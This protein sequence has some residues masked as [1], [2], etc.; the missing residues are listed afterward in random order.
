LT[1]S[2]SKPKIQVLSDEIVKLEEKMK[3]NSSSIASAKEKITPIH[4]FIQNFK[5]KWAIISQVHIIND[6]EIEKVASRIAKTEQVLNKVKRLFAKTEE[7]FIKITESEKKE[8]EYGLYKQEIK[9]AKQDLKKWD[10]QAKSRSI[11]EKEIDLVKKEIMRFIS[12]EIRPLT[13]I[14]NTLYLRAQGNRFINSIEARPSKEGFLEWIADLNEA[15]VSFD[16]MSSLSQGQRQDLALAI[17]L[18]RARSLGGTF[19]L[20]EPLAHLDDLNRV[21]LLDTLRIIVSERRA[22]NPLRLVLTTSSNNLLRH[23][24]E[25]F[26]LVED[27]NGSPALRIYKMNGN[28]RIGLDVELNELVHSP[29]KLLV[30]KG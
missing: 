13:N 19:F 16:K 7:Y 22:T 8:E 10:Y 20:D 5:R 27:G 11:V 21:A 24:R 15:G 6:T 14:I 17:F 26:S 30:N 23:L 4:N 25:K 2:D 12:E 3:N 1:T 29:N 28:P 9:E 18:A